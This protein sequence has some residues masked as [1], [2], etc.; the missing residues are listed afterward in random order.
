MCDYFTL[1]F[2]KM[3]ACQAQM[4]LDLMYGKPCDSGRAHAKPSLNEL[5]G[6]AS[7]RLALGCISASLI[8]R[9][10]TSISRLFTIL[11][12]QHTRIKSPMLTS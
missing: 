4:V 3:E 11:Y 5:T 7:A 6:T 8:S 2:D 9:Y 10:L 12:K 1:L